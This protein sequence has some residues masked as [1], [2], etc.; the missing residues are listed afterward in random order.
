[1]PRSSLEPKSDVWNP[2]DQDQTHSTCTI[3]C[4]DPRMMSLPR[5]PAK[6]QCF[7]FWLCSPLSPSTN[8]GTPPWTWQLILTGQAYSHY[9]RCVPLRRPP[10]AH[11]QEL[12]D[13]FTQLISDSPLTLPAPLEVWDWGTWVEE[14]M[15]QGLLLSSG[16]A[17]RSLPDSCHR[18]FSPC[19]GYQVLP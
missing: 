3:V 9:G 11:G 8:P 7:C 16:W 19:S 10:W 17:G 2:Q 4:P 6:G 13:Q 1:M 18:C 12:P 5:L 15:P 14:H